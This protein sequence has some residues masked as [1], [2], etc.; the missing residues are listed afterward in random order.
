MRKD[1]SGGALWSSFSRS[2]ARERKLSAARHFQSL[3]HHHH[4]GAP[5]DQGSSIAR[6]PPFLLF[7][8]CVLAALALWEASPRVAALR[9][10]AGAATVDGE[11]PGLRH[12]LA[13]G[14]QHHALARD[15]DG[16]GKPW[17]WLREAAGAHGPCSRL[18]TRPGA[19]AHCTARLHR[20]TPRTQAVCSSWT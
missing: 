1:L 10:R 4:H 6:H 8:S 17:D 13:R 16:P 14:R 11:A 18:L 9:R 12:C 7:L 5:L 19:G 3:S 2:A 20:M 15:H